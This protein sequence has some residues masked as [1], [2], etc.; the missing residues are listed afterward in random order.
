MNDNLFS[1]SQ[2]EP[3]SLHRRGQWFKSS[4]AHHP[5]SSSE[6][7]RSDELLNI[8]ELLAVIP[9]KRSH[10]SCIERDR[11]LIL[12][13]WR[14]GLRRAELANLLVQDVHGN[15]VIVRSGKNKKDRMVPLPESVARKLQEFIKDKGPGEKVFGLGGPA[16]GMKIKQFAKK[17]GLTDFHT[18]SLRHKYATDLLEA[19]VNI[20]VVQTLL[21]HENLNTTQV[22]LSITDQSLYDAVKKLDKYDSNTSRDN[23]HKKPSAEVQEVHPAPSSTSSGSHDPWTEA[24]RVAIDPTNLCQSLGNDKV[25]EVELAKLPVVDKATANHLRKL[26]QNDTR[27][28]KH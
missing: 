7:N 15:A 13:A 26:L 27:W 20:K 22:Y 6:G 11:L 25:R 1:G 14:S 17:A 5:D 19:G 28:H 21:G 9:N 8:R 4:T 23:K 3:L 12:M 10:K 18:H 16:I 24:L 2:T